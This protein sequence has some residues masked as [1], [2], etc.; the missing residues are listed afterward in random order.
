MTNLNCLLSSLRSATNLVSHHF[1]LTHLLG[2]TWEAVKVDS[3]KE[4]EKLDTVL[5]ELREILVD[6]LQCTLK[7]IF[8]DRGDL[9]F[10]ERLKIEVST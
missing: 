5:W 6:H 9:V 10:H 7:Y 8:H 4:R 3:T 2:L 1:T